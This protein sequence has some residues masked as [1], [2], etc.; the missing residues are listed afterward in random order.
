MGRQ[1]L[2]AWGDGPQPSGEKPR[3][4]HPPAKKQEFYQNLQFV[5]QP[6]PFVLYNEK[7][8][9]ALLTCVGE[10]FGTQSSEA[11]NRMM[12]NL[13]CAVVGACLM[14][15]MTAC[16]SPGQGIKIF[17]QSKIVL[18]QTE[19]MVEGEDIA[20]VETSEGSFKM[21]FFPS[22]APKT[23]E[24]FIEL[25]NAG[26]FDGQKVSRVERVEEESDTK[27][28]LIAGSGKPVEQE[29][30]SIYEEPIEPE[31][32][33]NLGTIPGAV[34]AY[35]PDGV[36]DSR[37][38]IV[39]S[40]EVCEEEIEEI[41]N[42]N[43]PEKLVEMFCE[44]GGYPEEW[45]NQ[46]VFA[47]VIEGMEV[48]DQI[49]DRTPETGPD[50]VTDVEIIQVRIEKYGGQTDSQDEENEEQAAL[51]ESSETTDQ[52]KVVQLTVGQSDS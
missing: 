3:A 36:V 37:F 5:Y 21:R 51:T 29:G 24:N 23:V 8:K 45:L 4:A 34:L 1:P 33:Y 19:E 49:I 42:S 35:A 20:V 48:V 22:E 10:P 18:L 38:Y 26:Y 31:L 25:A 2:L 9:R 14:L 46:S 13:S 43:Y 39:G 17:D 40:R 41:V 30:A 27:G 16:A 6:P 12:K 52:S 7:D 32:S 11:V 50:E 44:K 47:Q 28:R 15:T